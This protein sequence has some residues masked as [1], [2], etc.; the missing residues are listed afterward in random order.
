MLCV[1]RLAASHG[2]LP[3][4]AATAAEVPRWFLPAPMPHVC[5]APQFEVL[6]GWQ[7]AGRLGRLT[8]PGLLPAL[9]ALQQL[10]PDPRRLTQQQWKGQWKRA[11]K[12]ATKL[13]E[14]GLMGGR[15]EVVVGQAGSVYSHAA[16]IG[17]PLS[18]CATLGRQQH[19]RRACCL[20]RAI[21]TGGGRRR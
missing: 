5:L 1:L 15:R 3:P 9:T 12:E 8:E 17:A 19:E 20:Q 7:L 14:G 13:I 2:K 4:A 21:C 10:S 16:A 18:K 6:V 11:A